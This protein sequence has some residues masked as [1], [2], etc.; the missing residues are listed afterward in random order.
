MN[1]HKLLHT[2]GLNVKISQYVLKNLMD[3]YFVAHTLVL[4]PQFQFKR[5][6]KK[7]NGKHVGQ[8][9]DPLID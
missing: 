2:T 9:R 6:E 3:Y 5:E 4:A 1:I 7:L 8:I